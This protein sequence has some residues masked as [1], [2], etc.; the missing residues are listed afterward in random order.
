MG[1]GDAL[2]AFLRNQKGKDYMILRVFTLLYV[3]FVSIEVTKEF[4]FALLQY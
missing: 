4:F 2:G 1:D 3:F